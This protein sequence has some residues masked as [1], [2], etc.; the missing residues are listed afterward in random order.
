MK[1]D[2]AYKDI[3]AIGSITLIIMAFLI[4]VPIIII[5]TPFEGFNPFNLSDNSIK[6]KKG[7]GIFIKGDATV[8]LYNTETTKIEEIEL[9]EYIAGVVAAEMPANFESEALKAQ[10][11]AART[12]YFS[13]RMN[14]CPKAEGAEICNT[15]HCQV[16]ISK[17]ERLSKW[18]SSVAES[19][20][21]KIVDAVQGT[22][23]QVL[24]YEDE[25]VKY[26]QFFST[27]SGKTENSVDVFANEV[28]YLKSVDSPGEEVATRYEES[29]KV[30][31]SAF[32]ET[33]NNKYSK[34]KVSS[35]NI[36]NQI[37]ILS[38]T[39]G[40]A[41]KEIKLGGE[42]IKGTEFRTLF[43]LN[44]ANFTITYIG[45]EVVINCKGYGHGLGMS[46]WGA[47]AMAVNGS[48]YD[49]ILKHYYS[50]VDIEVVKYEG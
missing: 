2:D 33:I 39:D 23:G 7:E 14:P 45:S 46:Q 22:K 41:V 44:S 6:Y 36:Q 38:N 48:K 47:K 9:E 31:L 24:V 37:S 43:S 11:V 28:P 10:S 8:R 17:E 32:V 30:S 21:N 35:N 42:R 4:I 1:R 13:K 25:L 40:G 50:D 27:S 29:K 18:S 16:Y 26:P 5:K 12:F 20:W 34:A 3:T 49:E 15:T 19:N